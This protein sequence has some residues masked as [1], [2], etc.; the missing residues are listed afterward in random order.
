MEAAGFKAA[1]PIP[2]PRTADL[3]PDGK[4]L[5]LDIYRSLGGTE[6]PAKFRPGAWDLVF[7]GSLVVEL[8]EE[9]HFN[10]YRHTTLEPTQ[11]TGLPW[12]DTYRCFAIDHEAECLAA[13]RWGKRWTNPSCER[14]FGPADEP[15]VFDNVGSPRWKQ[16]ALYDAIKDVAALHQPRLHLV[17]IATLDLVDGIPLA[18]ALEH[19]NNIDPDA[20]RQLVHSRS[21]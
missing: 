4:D 13:G 2:P 1:E 20:L 14:M 11:T 9:L 18:S 10:R 15:G 21:T 17:R 12:R 7:E 5:V 8:D 16:R 3:P 6:S 19:R